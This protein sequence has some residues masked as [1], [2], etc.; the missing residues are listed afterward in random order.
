MKISTWM[1]MI[2]QKMKIRT[3]NTIFKDEEE[4]KK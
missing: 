4:P 2:M 3:C 1:M